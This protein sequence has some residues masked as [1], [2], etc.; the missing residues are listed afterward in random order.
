MD[1]LLNFFEKHL[2]EGVSDG[3]YDAKDNEDGNNGGQ[4]K[5]DGIKE[6]INHKTPHRNQCQNDKR[7]ETSAERLPIK[8]IFHK[9][10]PK[11]LSY[12]QL[13][14]MSFQ[15]LSWK[16]KISQQKNDRN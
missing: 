13:Y 1:Q 4:D 2:F 12:T 9:K 16:Q 11:N 5:Q 7:S 14:G 10:P 8:H 15:Y 3:I 6:K